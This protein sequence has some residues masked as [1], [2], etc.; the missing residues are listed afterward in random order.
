MKRLTDHFSVDRVV[1]GYVQ[2][3]QRKI[4]QLNNVVNL[5]DLSLRTLYLG[6]MH[7]QQTQRR[8]QLCFLKWYKLA[9]IT[10]HHTTTKDSENKDPVMEVVTPLLFLVGSKT[11]VR[12]GLSMSL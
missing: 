8:L 10:F 4:M 1:I 5:Y 6:A 2:G 11:R 12:R 7:Q 9:T 3:A